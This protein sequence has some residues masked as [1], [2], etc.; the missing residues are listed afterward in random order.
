MA[1][2]IVIAV[3]FIYWQSYSRNETNGTNVRGGA[4]VTLAISEEV[5]PACLTLY[6]K[7]K[8][9]NNL[10]AVLSGCVAKVARTCLGVGAGHSGTRYIYEGVLER[11]QCT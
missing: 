7:S 8:V 5:I 4:F 10:A 6:N 2:I 9:F 3:V 11:V 1:I